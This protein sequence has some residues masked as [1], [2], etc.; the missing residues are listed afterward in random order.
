[1]TE[2]AGDGGHTLVLAGHGSHTAPAAS[3]PIHAHADR[4]RTAGGFDEVS[5]AF[6]QGDPHLRGALRRARGERV[7]V[8]P[9]LMAAGYFADTVF[10]RELGL[11]DDAALD[12][13]KA[14]RYTAPVGTHPGITDVIVDRAVAATGEPDLGQGVGLAVVGHGTDRHAG[15]GVSTREHVAALRRA[16][17]FDEVR[18]FYLDQDPRVDALVTRM[19]SPRIVV[20]PLFVADGPHTTEDVPRAIGLPAEPSGPATLAGREV[21]YGRAV[22][23]APALSAV[24]RDLAES[25]D[26]RYAEDRGSAGPTD[27]VAAAR[28]FG[29]WVDA[30]REKRDGTRRWGQLAIAVEAGPRYSVRHRRDASTARDRLDRQSDVADLRDVIRFDDA[31]GFRPFSG[32]KTLP[33]GWVIDGHSHR[34]LSRIVETVYPASIVDWYRET[35]GALDG[36]AYAPTAERQTGRFA[37]LASVPAGVRR[38]TIAAC[39]TDC[40]RRPVWTDQ[41]GDGGPIPC[42]E[43]CSFLLHAVATVDGV[44]TS[45]PV[46]PAVPDGAVDRPGNRYRERS[47]RAR[48]RGAPTPAGGEP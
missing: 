29:R 37:G 48:D 45:G 21:W 40:S 31:G 15:S 43:P 14:V 24:I 8:V 33:T 38:A 47:L 17:R 25:D 20:V 2:P 36:T 34:E 13:A 32:A 18:A 44:E 39:C 23:T 7:T 5:V 16:D 30:A 28:A 22:G 42:R 12:V 41:G 4:L 6:W 19:G 26:A 10:P 11:T 46:D 35:E 3:E 27:A 1:M 9:M